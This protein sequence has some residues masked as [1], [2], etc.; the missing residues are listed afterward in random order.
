MRPDEIRALVSHRM[1]KSLESLRAAE[2]MLDN[3]MLSF[4]MNRIYYAL[5]YAVQAILISKNVSFS[6]HGPVKA[7]FNRELIKTGDLPVEMGRLFNKAFE[8]RQKFDYVD[9]AQP[10][11]DTVA[12][13]IES[14]RRFVSKIQEFL[15]EKPLKQT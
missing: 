9:F 3:G 6:K 15:Q 11:R 2:I 7:Y 5:F 10:E 1:D 14:A 8:Y 12:E 13:Y 4:G